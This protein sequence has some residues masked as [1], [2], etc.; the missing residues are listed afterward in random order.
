VPTLGRRQRF[1][2]ALQAP[3]ILAQ[4]AAVMMRPPRSLVREYRIPKEVLTEAYGPASTS[5]VATRESLRK[6]RTLL[7]ELG[8]VTRPAKRLWKTFGIWD[9]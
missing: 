8:L 7:V 5:R 6:V 1:S 4:M 3:F 2:I 9:K